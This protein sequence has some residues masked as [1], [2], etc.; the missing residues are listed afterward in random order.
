VS[1]NA[2]AITLDGPGLST[3]SHFQRFLHAAQQT[4]DYNHHMNM[5]YY[6]VATNENL[7]FCSRAA[8]FGYLWIGV[9]YSPV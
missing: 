2:C 5:G 4:I 9:Q 1:Q 8:S 7:C 3:G 6:L